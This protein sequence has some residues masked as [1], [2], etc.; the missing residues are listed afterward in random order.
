LRA[1]YGILRQELRAE[2]KIGARGSPALPRR[3]LMIVNF[4]LWRLSRVV[5]ALVTIT[6]GAAM[7]FMILPPTSAP[8]QERVAIS[9]EFRT[10]LEPYG[11][12]RQHARWGEVWIPAN[13]RSDWRPYTVGKW[14]YTEDYG[15]FWQAAAEEVVWGAVVYHYGRWVFEVEFGWIWVPDKVWGPSWVS[16]RHGRNRHVIGW[17]PLPPEEIIVEIREEPRYWVFVKSRDFVT[18]PVIARVVIPAESVLLQETVI[19]S[20]TV[21]VQR[22]RAVFA[23]NPGLSPSYVAVEVGRPIPAFEVRPRV[24]AGT[25]APPN[26]VVVRAE[27]FRSTNRRAAAVL[28]G[29]VRQ[30]TQIAPSASAK[31]PE[32]LS[33]PKQVRLGDDAPRAARGAHVVGTKAPAD[34]TSDAASTQGQPAQK[35]QSAPTR[36]GTETTS[37]PTQRQ[38]TR[39]G[40]QRRQQSEQSGRSGTSG[41]APSQQEGAG[42]NKSE[43]QRNAQ[44]S[45]D[46]RRDGSRRDRSP[47]DMTGGQPQ[48]DRNPDQGK[49]DHTHQ[50]STSGAAPAQQ[51]GT[52]SANQPSQQP[53]APRDGRNQS[54]SKPPSTTGN[55]PQRDQTSG[56]GNGQRSEGL[57]PEHRGDAP[58]TGGR[59]RDGGAAASQPAPKSEPSPHLNRAGQRS[60]QRSAR[61]QMRVPGQAPAPSARTPVREPEPAA[62]A[63]SPPGAPAAASRPSQPPSTTGS[64][65][66]PEGARRDDGGQR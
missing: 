22:E 37:S 21:V 52:S 20:Q 25:S 65:L 60:E 40:D 54:R 24:L 56:Q 3:M 53:E 58:G 8:A 42:A 38:S 66:P 46:G 59:E 28:Q 5:A 62:Q 44:S 10:A 16:W 61:P 13:R 17:A 55:Q 9:A 51:E 29:E 11:S 14:I 41:A 7:S 63:P 6:L 4:Q 64:G 26:G 12:F 1:L 18:A 23:V 57:R 43:Q 35:G 27:E 47:R 49:A 48:R 30:T 32:P 33:D 19:V 36:Q 31:P 39:P 50:P 2:L 45:R 15:W 34:N